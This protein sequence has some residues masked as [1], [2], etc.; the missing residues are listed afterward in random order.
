MLDSAPGKLTSFTLDRRIRPVAYIETI[1]IKDGVEC[2][3][4]V[5]KGDKTCDLAIVRVEAGHKT[6]LQKVLKGNKTIEGF[7]KGRA[8]LTV[9]SEDG[10]IDSYRF[11]SDDDRGREV[12]VSVGQTMQWLADESTR[13]VFYEIC[14]PPYEEGRYENLPE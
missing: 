9:T 13:L 14:D 3:V 7:L 5:F 11:D 1:H 8:T 6:P 12:I 10:G 4:Y 2:D